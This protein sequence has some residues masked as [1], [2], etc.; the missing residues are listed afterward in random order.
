MQ[1]PL[2]L[3]YQAEKPSISAP[4]EIT[5]FAV[6]NHAHNNAMSS[7]VWCGVAKILLTWSSLIFFCVGSVKSPT[8]CRVVARVAYDGTNFHGFQAQATSIRSVQGVLND[9]LARKIGIT[10]GTTGASRTDYGVHARGNCVHF[11]IPDTRWPLPWSLQ[12]LEFKL[13]RYLP[14]DI[15]VY[16]IS[17]APGGTAEEESHGQVFHATASTTGKL[18]SYRLC[19]SRVVDPLQRHFTTH[20]PRPFDV[21][22]L[23]HCLQKFVGT[24]DFVSFAN[25]I[26]RTRSDYAVYDLHLQ[27]TRTVDSINFTDEGG[28]YYRIDIRVAS[29]LYRMIRNIVG[30]S[31]HVAEGKLLLA[32]VD[33]LLSEAPGRQAN[34][35]KSAP[36]EGLVLE[37][38][39]YDDY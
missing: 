16:N 28:G 11:D 15:R 8:S 33:R 32:D 12:D 10:L 31:L 17:T 6:L 36:P 26:E 30:T 27:T 23:K 9:A 18:Y 3:A 1:T 29:A 39:Y 2:F 7:Y 5:S 38:V 21:E 24:H 4:H 22:V 34:K 13:N 14:D 37:H 35:A 25:K 20:Q 19:K